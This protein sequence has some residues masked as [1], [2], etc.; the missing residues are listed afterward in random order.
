[1]S[2]IIITGCAGFIGSNL[3][4][5]LVSLGHEVLGVDNFDP[6]YP[7]EIK[8]MNLA[9]LKTSK[10]FRFIEADITMPDFLGNITAPADCV[11][12]LASKA[13]VRPSIENAESY[14][15]TI[16]IGTTN[17]LEWMRKTGSKKMIYASSSSVY[18]NNKKVPFSETDNVDRPISPYAASKKACELLNYTYHHLYDLDIVNLRFFTVY[19]PRQRPDLA[20]RKFVELIRQDKPITLFG[21]GQTGRDYTYIDD[22]VDGICGAINYVHINRGVYEIFNLGNSN[23]VK[24]IELVEALYDLLGKRPQIE[25]APMQ[26]GDVDFTFA[27]ISKANKLLGYSPKTSLSSGLQKFIDWSA[28]KSG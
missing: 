26:S 16:V 25:F 18:G 10:H 27:D 22:I 4:E 15:R 6:F 17:V 1:M 28:S 7:R 19:G 24:L 13:G 9:G 12:H 20:I 21:D 14:I 2:S 8:E 23:P 5:K 11:V 3:A